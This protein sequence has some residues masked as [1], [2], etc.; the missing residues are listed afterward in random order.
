MG[1]WTRRL[2]LVFWSLFGLVLLGPMIAIWRNLSALIMIM[3]D[4]ATTGNAAPNSPA[5]ASGASAE[6]G[7]LVVPQPV[8]AAVL[9]SGWSLFGA[10]GGCSCCWS[11][12]RPCFGGGL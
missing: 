7:G 4:A 2:P 3:A 1:P 10:A 9:P 5:P 8:V 12:L 6:R 11:S